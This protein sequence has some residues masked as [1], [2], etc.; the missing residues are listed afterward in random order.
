MTVNLYCL[1]AVF[2]FVGKGLGQF[3]NLDFGAGLALPDMSAL[4]PVV[5]EPEFYE[6]MTPAKVIIEKV[7]A[8]PDTGEE[9]LVV[10]R[11]IGGQVADLTGWTMTDSKADPVYTFGTPG[12]EGNATILP[13]ESLSIT[14]QNEFNPCGFMFGISFRD[15]VVLYDDAQNLV[16]NVTWESSEKGSAIRYIEGEYIQVSELQTVDAVL[17]SVPEFSTFAQVISALGLDSALGGTVNP[18]Y[19]G[20][21]LPSPPSPDYNIEFPWWF[22][23]AQ[24]RT[25]FS[26]PPPPPPPPPSPPLGEVPDLGPY[27]VFAP[28]NA[29]FDQLLLLLGGGR[30]RIPFNVFLR[31]PEVESIV[32]YHIHYGAY[33]SEFMFNNTGIQSTLGPEVVAMKD[34]RWTEGLIAVND[35]CVDKPTTGFPCAQQLEF[36]KCYEPFMV[37]PLAVGWQGCFCLKTCQRH[38]LRDLGHERPSRLRSRRHHPSRKH[39]HDRSQSRLTKFTLLHKRGQ[40][41]K[42]THFSQ[43]WGRPKI[44][45]SGDGFGHSVLL[46]FSYRRGNRYCL[47]SQVQSQQD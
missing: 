15:T 33:T 29:A 10:L 21:V 13:M 44:R 16:G 12:C 18:D 17:K 26:P 28:T 42:S 20:V 27:T 45:D 30:V 36:D 32:L 24:D 19:T 47:L 40:S 38:R 31:L 37:S 41:A 35:A 34:P 3:G 23:F 43:K 39:F 5:E 2:L 11:N 6:G 1:L 46:D 22:G 7:V 9:D 14:P 8:Y 4:E 25:L